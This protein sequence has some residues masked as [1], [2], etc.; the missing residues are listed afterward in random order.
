MRAPTPIWLFVF[1]LVL[2]VLWPVGVANVQ[3]PP[4]VEP[5]TM[6]VF[7]RYAPVVNL[8]ANPSTDSAVLLKLK[9]AEV[10][11]L[12]PSSVT[13]PYRDADGAEQQW[14]QVLVHGYAG[15]VYGPLLEPIR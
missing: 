7:S 1:A 11:T 14:Q 4:D 3:P 5:K 13:L 10:V 12:T 9:N 8:R 6:R 2:T 15:W